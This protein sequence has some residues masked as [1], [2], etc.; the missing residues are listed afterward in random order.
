MKRDTMTH[1]GMTLVEVV[2]A[3]CLVSLAIGGLIPP[4]SATTELRRMA[5]AYADIGDIK[6]ALLGYAQLHGHLPC[7]ADP[8]LGV[9]APDAGVAAP[10]AGTDCRD[11]Y[12]GVVPWATLGTPPLDPWGH[13]YT[14]RVA[15]MSADGVDECR[16]REDR[17]RSMCL[18]DAAPSSH[19]ATLD[20]LEVRERASSGVFPAGTEPVA[21]QLAVVI[22]SH[23]A[24]GSGATHASGRPILPPDIAHDDE[25]RN[26]AATTVSYFA[27]SPRPSTRDCSDTRVA[28]T[29]CAF[30]DIVAWLSH[31][32]LLAGLALAGRL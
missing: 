28:A 27:G 12:H 2:V 3:L 10:L 7:P 30:D 8:R 18:P 13:R 19:H 29:R 21:T 9:A 25:R 26:A 20:Q 17:S 11:G 15:R 14:Y 1:H 23:G 31:A 22:V 6:L 16:Q 32:E 24:N 4:L 5:Q